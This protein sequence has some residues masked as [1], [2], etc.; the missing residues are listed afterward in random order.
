MVTRMAFNYVCSQKKK[1][2]KHKYRVL[3]TP[4]VTQSM[5]IDW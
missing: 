2:D 4:Y 1:Q 3:P 5:L